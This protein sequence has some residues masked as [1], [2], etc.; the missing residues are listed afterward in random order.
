MLIVV[1]ILFCSSYS[2]VFLYMFIVNKLVDSGKVLLKFTCFID[3]YFQRNQYDCYFLMEYIF[4]CV[5]FVDVTSHLC[6]LCLYV[7][8][9]ES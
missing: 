8:L 6:M 7:M 5:Q 2:F 3:V 9:S 1:C 4:L